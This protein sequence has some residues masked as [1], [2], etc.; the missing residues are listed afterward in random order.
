VMPAAAPLLV[1]TDE[2]RQFLERMAR[3]S[4]S[5]PIEVSFKPKLFLGLRMAWPSTDSPIIGVVSNSVR[6]WGHRF[7]EGGIEG[8]GQIAPGRVGVVR[9]SSLPED[10]GPKWC[11]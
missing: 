11:V 3:P 2:D 7:D 10:K 5:R 6:A 8:V 9:R 1:A 4:S